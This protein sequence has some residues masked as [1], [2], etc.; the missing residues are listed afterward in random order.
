MESEYTR[1]RLLGMGAAGVSVAL[2]HFFNGIHR[3]VHGAVSVIFSN[4]VNA[5]LTYGLVFGVWGFPEMGMP[6]AALG[7]FIATVARAAWLFAVL[8]F[9]PMFGVWA[10]RALQQS[11]SALQLAGGRG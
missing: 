2:G 9:G 4:V 1:I 6:G 10:M 3:P 11:P 7:T 8:A 5:V